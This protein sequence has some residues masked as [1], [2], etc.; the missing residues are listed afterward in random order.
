M[1]TSTLEPSLNGLITTG[2][3]NFFSTFLINIFSIIFSLNLNLKY[4]G[5]KILFFKNILFEISLSMA[6]AEDKTPECVYLIFSDS[7]IAWIYPSSPY[8]PCSAL[9]TTYGLNALKVL[10]KSPSGSQIFVI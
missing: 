3:P 8:L 10:I 6:T 1:Y 7:N 5:V 2:K 9:K 4:L